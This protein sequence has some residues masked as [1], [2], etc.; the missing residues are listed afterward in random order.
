MLTGLIVCF[1]H[2]V[3]SVN[4]VRSERAVC[5][6]VAVTKAGSVLVSRRDARGGRRRAFSP[7]NVEWECK[8]KNNKNGHA[9]FRRDLAWTCTLFF[10][11]QCVHIV[12]S[13]MFGCCLVGSIVQVW[14]APA[15]GR[16]WSW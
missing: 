13:C 4:A 6:N 8:R 9:R 15:D 16:G 2:V 3:C 7:P 11:T 1:V 12:C 14:R 5:D 10:G